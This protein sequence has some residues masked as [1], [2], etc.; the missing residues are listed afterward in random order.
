MYELICTLVV[1]CLV[2]TL[3]AGGYMSGGYAR[4]WWLH[5]CVIIILIQAYRLLLE[6]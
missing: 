6:L 1:T 2:G 5:V 3:V 4:R